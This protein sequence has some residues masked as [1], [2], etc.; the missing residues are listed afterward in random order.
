MLVVLVRR[1][2]VQQP[3]Q[4]SAHPLCGAQILHQAVLVHLVGVTGFQI[5]EEKTKRALAD[6][7][8]QFFDL[9]GSVAAADLFQDGLAFKS[10]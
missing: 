7:L 8:K 5:D 3:L 1:H 6:V 9:F 4:Q 10:I 2:K